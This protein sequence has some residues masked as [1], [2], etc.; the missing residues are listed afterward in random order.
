MNLTLGK[1]GFSSG[2]ILVLG[3]ELVLELLGCGEP[4]T[5]PGA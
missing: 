2:D 3:Q 5:S 4:G 1:C